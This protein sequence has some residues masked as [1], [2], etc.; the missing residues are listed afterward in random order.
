MAAEPGR[1]PAASADVA[2][3]ARDG[4]LAGR[5]QL[6]P[7][8]S[9]LEFR[10]RHF[11]HLI[12]VRGR[13][14]RLTG[15]GAV[16][17]DGTLTGQ[18]VIDAG[19]LNTKNKARDKHLRSA[20]FFDSGRHPRVVI[21]VNKAALADGAHVTGEGTLEAAGIREPISFTADVAD[22][23]PDAITLR[24]ELTVDRSRFG[25]TWSPMRVASMQANGSVVA[26]FTRE[27]PAAG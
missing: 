19:S 27:S 14:E 25:M 8:A 17:P 16:G 2:R 3:L 13:F 9:W 7:Q 21:T 26:R 5:W 10:V 4:A 15:E 24:A 11:W 23:G 18:L 12:T 22:A 6:D 1:I 20:D